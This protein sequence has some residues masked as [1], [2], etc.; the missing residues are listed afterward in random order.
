MQEGY[1]FT[2]GIRDTGGR[3]PLPHSGPYT[4][5]EPS[6]TDHEGLIPAAGAQGVARGVDTHGADTVGVS[7]QLVEQSACGNGPQGSEH[8]HSP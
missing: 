5:R 1:H 7:A 2:H 4:A 8:T 6:C 3:N